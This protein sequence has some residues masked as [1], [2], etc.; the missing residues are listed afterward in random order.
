MSFRRMVCTVI[1]GGGLLGR[2]VVAE[3]ALAGHEVYSYGLSNHELT[4]GKRP[5]LPLAHRCEGET[6]FGPLSM[7]PHRRLRQ[8]WQRAGRP[9]APRFDLRR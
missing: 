9:R 3:L 7:D 6:R 5:L 2:F 4:E 1:G 8:R